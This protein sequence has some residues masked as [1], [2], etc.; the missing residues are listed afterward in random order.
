MHFLPQVAS[1]V[2]ESE[3]EVFR[4][5]RSWIP[6][7]TRSRSR[8]KNIRLRLWKYKWIIFYITLL[9]WEF[10]LKLLLTQRILAVYHDFHWVLVATKFLTVKC[11][12][13]YVKESGILENSEL[14]ILERSELESDI[15]PPTPQPWLLL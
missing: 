1:R 14:E 5:S 11:H 12:S 7:Y 10:L 4:W 15:L 6:N 9:S 2:A 3:S 13:L 8:T